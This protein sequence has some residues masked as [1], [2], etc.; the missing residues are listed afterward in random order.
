MLKNKFKLFIFMLAIG[1]V[2]ITLDVN[3]TTPLKYPHKYNNSGSAIGEF[4][5]YNI[6]SNYNAWC[7]YKVINTSSEK[8]D[9][10]SHYNA[11]NDNNSANSSTNTGQGTAKV[12]DHVYFGNISVDIFSDALGFL[13][14]FIACLNLAKVNNRFKYGS[15]TA[16]FALI[17]HLTILALPFFLNGIVLCNTAL[18]LGLAYL[19][20]NIIT[21]FMFS[22]GLLKMCT[23]ICC[24]DERKWCKMIWFVTFVLQILVT[25]VF[26]IGSDFNMLLAVGRFFEGVLVFMVIVFWIILKRTYYYLER[27]WLNYEKQN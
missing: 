16:L 20:S 15:V 18:A 11:T 2:L 6:A 27:T 23:D 10:N 5:Y 12:I 9:E 13:L 4:Q 1:F 14:I 17:L 7:D 25:F 8:A 24:R 22:S 3:V 26:W 21:T 19:G